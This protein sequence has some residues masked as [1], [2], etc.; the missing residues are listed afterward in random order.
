MRCFILHI[1][2]LFFLHKTI[3]QTLTQN[4]RGKVVDYITQTPLPGATIIL[5]TKDT[6]FATTSNNDGYFILSKIPVGRH[7]IKVTFVGYKTEIFQN[8]LLHSA[9]EIFLEIA[10][11][12]QIETL[13]EVNVSA[14]KNKDKPLEQFAT[15]SARS[16]QVEQT[17]RFAGSLGDV[18][19]MVGNYAGVVMQNDSRNDII[20]RGNSPIGVIWRLDD[21]EIPNP[22]HFAALGTTGGPVCMLN[23]NLL[24]NSD[25]YTGAFPAQFGNGISGVFDLKM[26]AGNNQKTEFTGQVGFNGFELGI[27]GPFSKKS[28]ASYLVNARYSTLAV[29][30]KLGFGTGT[31]AAI[32]YYKDLSF[33]I[34]V[35]LKN[36]SALSLIGLY[37]NSHIDMGSDIADTTATGYRIVDQHT[38]FESALAVTALTYQCSFGNHTRLKS[39]ISHLQTTDGTI[40]DNFDT[41]N[42]SMKPYFRSR[43]RV[44]VIS[45]A[46]HGKTKINQ[47]NYVGYGI[48]FKKHDIS[49][50]DSVLIKHWNRFIRLHEITKQFNTTQ[51]YTQWQHWFSE[52][53]KSLAG[54]HYV[55]NFINNEVTI[56]PRLGVEYNFARINTLSFGYG[57]HTQ[58]QPYVVYYLLDYDSLNNE[59]RYTNK[60]IKSTR[61]HHFVVSYT[62]RLS[63]NILF[64]IEPYYQWLFKVP[65]STTIPS[66]SLINAGEFFNILAVDSLINKGFGKNTGIEF[67]LEQSLYKGFYWLSTFSL[68]DSKYKAYDNKWRNTAFNSRFVINTLVG[69]EFKIKERNFV[70][71]DVKTIYAGGKRYV[72]IDLERSKL[73]GEVYYDFTK[74]YENKFNDYFKL[75]VRIGY[76]RNGKK[77]TQEW[78]IDLQNLTQNKAVIMQGYSTL[79]KQIYYIHQS[80]FYPMFLYRILF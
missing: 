72:P 41:T 77:S 11:K 62:L 31:G 57:Y 4:I 46:L 26:R 78:A 15:V 30:H 33:K 2:I 79:R 63:E 65:V 53:I 55:I 12:E 22:N 32:P 40:L 68:F 74:A 44:D 27:E 19:R 54:F 52:N 35:P 18:A 42:S 25:F 1:F 80:A 8:I 73:N 17:E 43:N 9:K 64:K 60:N 56:E 76:K 39:I 3:A 69:Y 29:M 34:Y 13:N 70:T 28:Y 47:R 20:I 75:D 58:M 51:I 50:T 45:I 24:T 23:N 61:A 48:T 66:Y 7:N 36:S 6:I 67:T 16:F 10:L 21:V 38:A 59:Y 71:F 5:Q 37:G 49:L 14:Q